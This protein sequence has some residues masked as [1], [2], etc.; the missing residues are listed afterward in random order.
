M[1]TSNPPPSTGAGRSDTT[2][3]AAAASAATGI[4]DTAPDPVTP[5]PAKRP[6]GHPTSGKY[7]RP[8]STSSG[9]ADPA[10]DDDPADDDREGYGGA[11]SI[12][13]GPN[14]RG[15]ARIGTSNSM[16]P[17][18][19]IP[20]RA[21]RP[22]MFYLSR[23]RLRYRMVSKIFGRAVDPKAVQTFPTLASSLP[24]KHFWR[25]VK[26]RHL[27]GARA[28]ITG[29]RIKAFRLGRSS[30]PCSRNS[31]RGAG[32]YWRSYSCYSTRQ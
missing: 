1:S 8:S 28:E 26:Q 32:K 15:I 16:I 29:T 4:D 22:A 23:R 31:T 25:F 27:F 21:S 14:T 13:F 19:M 12:F 11:T 10:A 6:A 17:M 18:Q 20:T 5:S 30:S 24:R 3:A 2:G 9:E 7:Q